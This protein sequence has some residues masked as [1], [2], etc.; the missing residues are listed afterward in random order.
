MSVDDEAGW[1]ADDGAYAGRLLGTGGTEVSTWVSFILD[2]GGGIRWVRLARRGLWLAVAFLGLLVVL[3]YTRNSLAKSAVGVASLAG[4]LSGRPYLAE[5]W[6][7]EM[8]DDSS[9]PVTACSQMHHAFG[10]LLA[11]GRIRLQDLGEWAGKR[12]DS[13]LASA[14]LTY[15]AVGT[16]VLGISCYFLR[17]GG[18]M[19]FMTNIENVAIAGVTLHAAAIALRKIRNVESKTRRK[20][21]KEQKE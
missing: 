13:F 7:G 16:I 9:G 4:R 10:F 18:V 11:A 5:S 12:L 3:T 6:I 15:G 14:C 8:A 20:P 2:Y 19:L 17:N 21:R 1:A